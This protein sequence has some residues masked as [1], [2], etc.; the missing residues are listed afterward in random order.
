MTKQFLSTGSTPTIPTNTVTVTVSAIELDELHPPLDSISTRKD[1][2]ATAMDNDIISTNAATPSV[3][4][5]ST[6]I[7]INQSNASGYLEL[8]TELHRNWIDCPTIN[9]VF[10]SIKYTVQIPH[11]DTEIHNFLSTGLNGIKRLFTPTA[12]YMKK[13]DVLNTMTG[14]I[15]NST[16]TL[17][18][19]APGAGKSALLKTLAGRLTNK[20]T[21]G[22]ILYNGL[23]A[24]DLLKLG[25]NPSRLSTY[26]GQSDINFP[27][28]TV[29][30]T[31][32][33]SVESTM[34]DVELLPNYSKNNR[35]I[36][37]NAN[38]VEL[39]LKLLGLTECAD[40][41]IG[42]DLLRGISKYIY[43]Y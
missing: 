26:I 40:T 42:S 13:L 39:L 14:T 20:L 8:I 1:S 2:T 15:R 24:A 4:I 38:R 17:I 23:T 7:T 33:F 43:Y 19:S 25:I 12:H 27:L 11:R 5:P 28:L 41:I 35:L 22:E 21:T 34:A 16:S 32:K 10:N 6:A 29:R 3:S 37:L 18:L 30:E 31:I 36:E 9:I